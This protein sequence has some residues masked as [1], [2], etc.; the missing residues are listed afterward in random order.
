MTILNSFTLFFFLQSMFLI[1]S[2][3]SSHSTLIE[4]TCQNTPYYDV[5]INSLTSNPTS[6]SVDVTGLALIMV[7]V[8]ETKAN[9]ALNKINELEKTGSSAGLSSCASK[10]N[11]ILVNDIP[12]AIE[13]LQ[14]GD[15]KFAE[16]GANDAA[17]EANFCQSDITGPLTPQNGAMHNVAIVTAAIVRLLL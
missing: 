16:D 11:A 3:P 17:N 9:D 12:S 4:D 14:K 6:Y 15:P 8:M 7:K 1:I 13:A 2:I 5:C 10:Y